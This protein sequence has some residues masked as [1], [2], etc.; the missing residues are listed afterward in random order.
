LN[1]E[2]VT[3]HPNASEEVS[4]RP[5]Q[6]PPVTLNLPLSEVTIPE[7]L[8]SAGYT[9]AFFGKWHVSAHYDGKYLQWSPTYGPMAQGFTHEVFDFG[10]HPYNQKM[11]RAP[12]DSYDHGEF[13]ADSL[14]DQAVRFI[15]EAGMQQPFLLY[16]SHFY[17]HD[18]VRNQ[19]Q[20]LTDKYAERLGPDEAEVRA[21]YAASVEI[22]DH[23]IG[24]VLRAI[25]ETGL[26]EN[27]VVVLF[28][29]NGGDPRY[30]RH[31]PL[32]GHKWTLYEGGVRVPMVVRWPGVVEE[33]VTCDVPVLGMDFLPTIAEIAG[34]TL[35]PSIT[36]DGLSIA[37]LLRGDRETQSMG[38][39]L[40]WHFPYYHGKGSMENPPTVAG[41]NDP[42]DP[43]LGPHSTLMEWPWKVIHWYETGE[44]E[45]FNLESD[46]SEQMNLAESHDAKRVELLQDLTRLLEE[47][48][49]RLP[50]RDGEFVRP[51]TS[52]Q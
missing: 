49:A 10:M 51:M 23:H 34:A 45:V 9:S 19:V 8:E 6:P 35:D 3:R 2:F 31:A 24:S 43:L 27:T 47:S 40:L 38:R 7:V 5:L 42:I 18:P 52:Q 22:M 25:D 14:T 11:E 44:T 15:H 30:T 50:T 32:R 41:I 29:D 17:V 20:W 26:R 12:A 1:F 13:P 21:E 16:L 48:N 28:S 39:Q 4:K 46:P 37:D 33:G 36:L